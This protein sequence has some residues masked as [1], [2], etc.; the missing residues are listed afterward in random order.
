MEVDNEIKEF[1]TSIRVITTLLDSNVVVE[2]DNGVWT[3][4]NEDR[5][6]VIAQND[7]QDLTS[8]TN[9]V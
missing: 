8:F 3:G 9:G 1:I 5:I 2:Y 4:I 6:T 7:I